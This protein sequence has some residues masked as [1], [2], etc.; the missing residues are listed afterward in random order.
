MMKW[1]PE[2]YEATC[3]SGQPRQQVQLL[4]ASPL[5]QLVCSLSAQTA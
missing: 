3:V 1:V 5:K 4:Y 2:R